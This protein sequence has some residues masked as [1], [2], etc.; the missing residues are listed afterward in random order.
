[1]ASTDVLAVSC[2]AVSPTV[3]VFIIAVVSSQGSLLLLLWAPHHSDGAPAVD[4]R[5]AVAS[6]PAFATFLLL[7]GS[8]CFAVVPADWY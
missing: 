7:L 6:T 2:A 5:P 1:M 3:A 4:G 8:C